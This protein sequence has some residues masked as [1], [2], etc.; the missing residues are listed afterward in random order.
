[1]I[2][3]PG[4][5]VKKHIRPAATHFAAGAGYNNHNKG[6]VP[7]NES[8]EVIYID[9]LLSI[10]LA[11]NYFLLMASLR[12]SG[13]RPKRWRILLGAAIG[14]AYSLIILLPDLFWPI[15]AATRAVVCLLMV[16]VCEWRVHF[17]ELLCDSLI[18]FTVSF[19]FA[20]FMLALRMFVVPAAMIY[21]N[22]IV[23]LRVNAL[24]L[25][26]AAVAA[27]LIVELFFWIFR[28]RTVSK[29]LLERL[30]LEISSGGVTITAEGC[31]DTGNSLRDPLSGSP[32]AVAGRGVAEKLFTEETCRAICDPASSPDK[33]GNVPGFRLIPCGTVTGS[34]LMPVFRPDAMKLFTKKG[35]L[36]AEDVLIGFPSH[37]SS[38]LKADSVL[39]SPDILLQ[40]QL[41]EIK[42]DRE[43]E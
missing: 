21:S 20:G 27:Y 24:T 41:P 31:V 13:R 43:R 7:V 2:T 8:G 38:Q 39:L 12:L 15:Q 3:F 35:V 37:P 10:N 32:V 18:F 5:F 36:T 11:V 16:L 25:I 19:I 28:R 42:I 33:L 9:I 14:A 30:T 23:Y 17:C 29:K 4:W 6:G 34:G 26:L 40:K 1:M 22:G